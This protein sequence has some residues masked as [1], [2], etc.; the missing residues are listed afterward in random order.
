MFLTGEGVR[1][2]GMP[3]RKGYG[4][5]KSEIRISDFGIAKLSKEA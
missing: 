1:E 3:Q 4:N 5:P 2:L